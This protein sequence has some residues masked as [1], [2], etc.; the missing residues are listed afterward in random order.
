VDRNTGGLVNGQEILALVDYPDIVTRN[1]G[2]VSVEGVR[3]IL[4]VFE[5]GVRA[6]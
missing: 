3:D 5:D 1:G 6:G 4:T 2:F